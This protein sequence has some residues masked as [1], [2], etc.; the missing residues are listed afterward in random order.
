MHVFLFHAS[1]HQKYQEYTCTHAR[2]HTHVYVCMYARDAHI[3]NVRRSQDDTH[4]CF[5]FVQHAATSILV[6]E[7]CPAMR[8]L[9]IHVMC[10]VLSG[11]SP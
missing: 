2:T 4:S 11:R 10:V 6:I 8:G 9:V 3:E 1:S 5:G 7:A